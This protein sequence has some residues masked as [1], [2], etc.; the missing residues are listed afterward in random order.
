RSV[1][2][3]DGTS[4]S[5][6]T[7]IAEPMTSGRDDG[8]HP[9]LTASKAAARP[10]VPSRTAAQISSDVSAGDGCTAKEY[11]GQPVELGSSGTAADRPWRPT[12]ATT[13]TL[14][15]MAVSAPV[16]SHR[17]SRARC[18]SSASCCRS[19]EIS[20]SREHPASQLPG[21]ER[22]YLH[23]TR[24]TAR[25][26][27][28]C[29][30]SGIVPARRTVPATWFIDTVRIHRAAVWVLLAKPAA[31]Q[32]RLAAVTL[33]AQ[34]ARALGAAQAVGEDGGGPAGSSVSRSGAVSMPARQTDLETILVGSAR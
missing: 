12:T 17:A 18:W 5:A 15:P 28:K 13:A 1:E 32:P 27:R 20:L 11:G 16:A 22:R 25:E 4:I 2:P 34:A 24:S 19:T 30:P 26:S 14:T 29:L 23:R 9:H 3:T 8:R 33:A 7:A 31:L 21:L 6:T 10:A